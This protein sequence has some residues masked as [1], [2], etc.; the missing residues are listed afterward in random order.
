VKKKSFSLGTNYRRE[1]KKVNYWIRLGIRTD[2]AYRPKC[3]TFRELSFLN[4]SEILRGSEQIP[5]KNSKQ[6]FA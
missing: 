1:L 3:W 2:D 6:A 4:K 5:K